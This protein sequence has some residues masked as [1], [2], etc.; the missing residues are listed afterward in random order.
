[1]GDFQV[2]LLSESSEQPADIQKQITEPVLL[3]SF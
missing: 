2:F 3:S 1:M